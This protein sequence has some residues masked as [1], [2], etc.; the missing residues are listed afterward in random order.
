MSFIAR[1][2]PFTVTD[3]IRRYRLEG[4]LAGLRSPQS[5]G[6]TISRIASRWACTTCRT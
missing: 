4:I 2:G 3:L 6:E 1:R 5:A